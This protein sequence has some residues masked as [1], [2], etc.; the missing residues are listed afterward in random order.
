[1]IKKIVVALFM[2][3]VHY[4]TLAQN[5]FSWDLDQYHD[6]STFVTLKYTSKGV[7][8]GDDFG[9]GVAR[10]LSGSSIS[11]TLEF[12]ITDFCGNSTSQY[13]PGG[14]DLK[15]GETES[16][17]FAIAIKCKELRKD[18]A[19]STGIASVTC[20]VLSFRN[21]TEEANKLKEE[22]ERKERELEE[23]RRKREK[24]LA[25][26]KQAEEEKAA[27][28]KKAKAEKESQ[29]KA[30]ADRKAAEEKEAQTKKD[31]E[32]AKQEQTDKE[33]ELQDEGT[34]NEKK[35]ADKKAA[36][37]KA[38]DKKAAEKKPPTKEEQDAAYLEFLR[39]QK[40]SQAKTLETEGDN[41]NK[42]GSAFTGMALKKY[43]EAQTYYYSSVVQAKIDRINT[44]L[45]AAKLVNDGLDKL[46]DFSSD[47]RETMDGAGLTKWR[48]TSFSYEGFSPGFDGF[49][50]AKSLTPQTYSINY[51]FYRIFAMEMGFSYHSSPVYKMGLEDNN[52]A[53][54]GRDVE[55]SYTSV[56]PEIA[57]GLALPLKHVA[58]YALYGFSFPFVI[59]G[60]S[61]SPEYNFDDDFKDNFGIAIPVR[62]LKFGAFINIPKTRIGIGLKYTLNAINGEKLIEG[63]SNSVTDNNGNEYGLG[64]GKYSA[65]DKLKYN[66]IGVSFII[67]SKD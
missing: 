40:E 17:P 24:E 7:S 38:A 58:V 31:E 15:P 5:A 29:M 13:W 55:G 43:E 64:K 3:C 52:N 53:Y 49:Q 48:L 25:E 14:L 9:S 37:K 1:M 21:L 44:T 28:D 26:K 22:K 12:I 11:L 18:G 20:Q 4:S 46:E 50:T 19:K 59:S 57:I 36:D 16:F 51:G 35:E 62:K 32:R 47:M 45:A 6:Y 65:V 10:N 2:I 66:S 8:L 30:E 42:M 54:T 39:R 60:T 63:S 27:A 61:Y 56:G 34:A 33:K 67:K 41:F 23:A